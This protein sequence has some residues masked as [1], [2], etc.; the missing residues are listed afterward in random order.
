MNVSVFYLKCTDQSTP[1]WAAVQE[2]AAYRVCPSPAL[3]DGFISSLQCISGKGLAV[4]FMTRA[5]ENTVMRRHW[6]PP[7]PISQVALETLLSMKQSMSLEGKFSLGSPWWDAI[8]LPL[9]VWKHR[10]YHDGSERSRSHQESA[11]H[12]LMRRSVGV[13]CISLGVPRDLNCYHLC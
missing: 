1:H 4:T 10:W 3:L 6:G 13:S 7:E 2:H 5:C 9:P 8:H 11:M 12:D